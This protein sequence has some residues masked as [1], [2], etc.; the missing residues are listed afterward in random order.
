MALGDCGRVGGRALLQAGTRPGR[1]AASVRWQGPLYL[2]VRFPEAGTLAGVREETSPE[3]QRLPTSLPAQYWA[4]PKGVLTPL[5]PGSAVLCALSRDGFSGRGPCTVWRGCGGDGSSR[6]ALRGKGGA[7]VGRRAE[8]PEAWKVPWAAAP[9]LRGFLWNARSPGTEG[10][11]GL[12][13]GGSSVREGCG[14]WTGSGHLE[15]S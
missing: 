14:D 6:R 9:T 4:S 5:P 2:T 3:P 10:G 12:R 15:L 1:P 11:A 7:P 13:L 8:G